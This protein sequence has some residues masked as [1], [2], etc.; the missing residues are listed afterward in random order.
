MKESFPSPQ[1]PE[2]QEGVRSKIELHF[3]RHSIKETDKTK[4]DADIQLTEE[5][6]MLAKSKAESG[7][8]SQSLVYGS[9]K[10]RTRQTAGLVMAGSQEGVTGQE[11]LEELIAKLDQGLQYGTK[12]GTERLLEFNDDI[13]TTY[14]QEILGAYKRGEALSWLVHKSDQTA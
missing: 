3:F 4:P 10:K 7:D 14:G 1:T 6:R 11:S 8:L 9:P 5:G 13:T 12:V 2:Q